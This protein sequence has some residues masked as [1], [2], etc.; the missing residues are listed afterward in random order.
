MCLKRLHQ[1]MHTHAMNISAHTCAVKEHISIHTCRKVHTTSPH[2]H[3]GTMSTHTCHKD[4]ISTHTHV[5][6]RS[7]QHTHTKL[8]NIDLCS[9]T[10]AKV[11]LPCAVTYIKIT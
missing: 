5:L 4:H 1:H 2:A 8:R 11:T 3:V 6:Q 9:K 10:P 7:H